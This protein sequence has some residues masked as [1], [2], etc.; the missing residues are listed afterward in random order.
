MAWLLSHHPFVSVVT[1]YI[2]QDPQFLAIGF[3]SPDFL[4]NQ[5]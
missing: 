2:H 4:F 3:A 5:V 1:K